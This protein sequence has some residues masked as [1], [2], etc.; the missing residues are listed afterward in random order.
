[1]AENS[2]IKNLEEALKKL[3]DKTSKILFYVFDSRGV[4]NGELSYIYELAY[5]LKELGYNVQILYSEKEFVGVESWLGKKYAELPHYNIEKDAVDVAAC[6]VLLIPDVCVQVMTK[7][8]EFPCKRVMILE[9]VAYL[10][11]MIPM[12][13]SLDDLRI[14]EIVAASQE[15]ADFA[16]KNFGDV[17]V[18][19]VENCVNDIFF[20][21]SNKPK[22]L[23][24]NVISK[25]TTDTNTILKPFYWKYPNYAWVAFRELKNIPREDYAKALQEGFATIWADSL[26]NFGI[27]ALEAMACNNVVIGK[28]P[29]NVP[30]WLS[31][32]EGDL[33]NNG[34]WFYNSENAQDLIASVIQS[35]LLDAIPS[36]LYEEMSKTVNAYTESKQTEKIKR[37]FVD[38]ILDERKKELTVA[39]N[40]IKKI[41][42]NEETKTDAE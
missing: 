21:N 9:N 41:E 11:E 14:R 12:G 8:K 31:T 3:E 32:S 7:T 22:K 6:D 30:D 28:I 5:K 40:T 16:K 23:I 19:V 27:S 15:L 42:N 37:V 38:G 1:M 35:F 10:T 17:R 20:D 24:I 2:T 18:H 36:S 39:K 26:T 25:S 13:V 29:E 4:P 34:V 33:I